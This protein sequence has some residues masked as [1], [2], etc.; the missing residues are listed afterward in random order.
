MVCFTASVFN[1][2]GDFTILR[3]VDPTA[4]SHASQEDV[5]CPCRRVLFLVGYWP[6]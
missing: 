2:Q 4:G 3:G 5:N 6:L 1:Q